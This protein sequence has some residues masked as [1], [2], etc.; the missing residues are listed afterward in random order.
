M[1]DVLK[2]YT[3]EQH[4][5]WDEHLDQVVFS[6]NTSL[7]DST[8]ETPHFLLFGQ[9][10][11]TTTQPKTQ[12][13][14]SV[15]PSLRIAK[16]NVESQRQALLKTRRY[17]SERLA[18][19]RRQRCVLARFRR[20]EVASNKVL[21]SN[22]ARKKGV[23]PKLSSRWR[24]PYRITQ[25]V[26]TVL[27]RIQVSQRKRVVVHHDRLK[28]YEERPSHLQQEQPQHR[29]SISRTRQSTKIYQL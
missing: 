6:Y 16:E 21:L 26:S 1:L 24:G 17:V 25:V 27:Y 23:S 12:D 20:Y 9:E 11:R 22:L 28:P 3:N 4:I 18:R 29:S 10:A 19:L 8:Q 2:D 13:T 5:D 14:T 7:H 15:S